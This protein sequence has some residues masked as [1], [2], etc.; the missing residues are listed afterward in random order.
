[1]DLVKIA[2]A[3]AVECERQQ[4]DLESLVDLLIAYRTLVDYNQ[5]FEHIWQFI[6]AGMT[7][8]P[9]KNRNG[10]RTTPVT[11]QNGGSS[12]SPSEI[13]RLMDNLCEAIGFVT[14]EVYK[15]SPGIV[16]RYVREFLWI[17]PF[18][19]GNGRVGFL[20]QNYLDGTLDDP[21]PLRNHF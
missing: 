17:H 9:F 10:W 15:N 1:M 14:A 3:C 7:V 18:R 2:N 16:D 13:P 21:Q 20:L 5:G 12:A 6:S 19:D 4:V 8:E 11:F